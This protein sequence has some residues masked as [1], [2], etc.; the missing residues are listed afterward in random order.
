[1]PGLK[2]QRDGDPV[3]DGA[4]WGAGVGLMVGLVVV[5]PGECHIQWS[6]TRCTLESAMWGA[7]IGTFID[8]VNPGRTTVFSAPRSERAHAVRLVPSVTSASKRLLV[9]L[10]F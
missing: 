6:A 3:W 2:V 10:D 4:A 9:Q 8:W 1:M 5:A 7:L